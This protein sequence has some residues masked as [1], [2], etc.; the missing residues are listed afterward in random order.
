MGMYDGIPTSA[1]DNL[2]AETC[3]YMNIIHPSYSLLAA[4]IVVSNLHKNTKD[5]FSETIKDLYTYYDEKTK[6]DCCLIDT[7]VYEII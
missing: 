7:E 1:L 3:A 2:A 5:D 6:R 4:R